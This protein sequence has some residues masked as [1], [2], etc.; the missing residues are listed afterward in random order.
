MIAV[1]LDALNNPQLAGQLGKEL[2]ELLLPEVSATDKNYSGAVKTALL[3][4]LPG[5]SYE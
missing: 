1:L 3:E 4:L 2:G 5:N